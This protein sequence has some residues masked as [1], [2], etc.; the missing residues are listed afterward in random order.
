[1]RGFICILLLLA[2]GI[3]GCKENRSEV[4]DVPT[5]IVR[6]PE[7]SPTPNSDF[8]KVPEIDVKPLNKKQRANLDSTLP[9][10]VRRILAEADTLEVFGLS[11]YEKAGIG[12]YPDVKVSL[13]LGK[14]RT[15][16]LDSFFFDA[17]AGPNSSA[18]FNP[19]HGLKATHQG[20]TI[21]V[22]ICYECSM[23]VVKGDLGEFTGGIYT[24]VPTPERL[25]KLLNR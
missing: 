18:C 4:S 16:L 14:E 10:K 17:S 19:R 20:K 13:S 1:M 7:S 24:K 6:M 8:L 2:I 12:W 15:E 5:P 3:C 9:L 23:F 11:S 25:K 21:E 22:V